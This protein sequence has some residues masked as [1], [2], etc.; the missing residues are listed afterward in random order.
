MVSFFEMTEL[1]LGGYM[2][3]HERAA[4]FGGSDGQPYSAAIYVEDEPDLRGPH[5]A[6]PLFVRWSPAGDRPIGHLETD[7]PPGVERRRKPS[8]GWR[9]SRC[10]MSKPRWTKP[11]PRRRRVGEKP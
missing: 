3:K 7:T 9:I 5:G 6:A 4:A 1:T 8:L 11:Y 2:R 10:T